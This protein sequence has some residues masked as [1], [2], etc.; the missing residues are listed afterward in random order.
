MVFLSYIII[1]R[2]FLPSSLV[3]LPL[4]N[5]CFHTH[6]LLHICTDLP[7]IL[8]LIKI[9]PPPTTK[10]L[11]LTLLLHH[12]FTHILIH[13]H[14]DIHIW[15]SSIWILSAPPLFY[16]L[17]GVPPSYGARPLLHMV[18]VLLQA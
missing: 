9:M 3:I 4:Q 15:W 12:S 5:L 17:F 10:L 13:T 16:L 1:R 6:K 18:L 8:L 7:W 14:V 11:P 2:M